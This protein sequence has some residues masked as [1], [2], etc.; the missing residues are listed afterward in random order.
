MHTVVNADVATLAASAQS[1]LLIFARLIIQDC[2][3]VVNFLD[4]KDVLAVVLGLLTENHADFFG[5]YAHKVSS[6]AI[7]TLLLSGDDRLHSVM[8]KGPEIR[9][10][11]LRTR[12]KTRSQ[13][14]QQFS[15]VPA[16]QRLFQILVQE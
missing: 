9:G 15:Q 2:E 12:S 13:G 4:S 1:L 10:E 3:T 8:V 6:S 11:G 16:A 14:G 7:T 5:A